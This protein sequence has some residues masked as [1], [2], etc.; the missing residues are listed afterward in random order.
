MPA[1]LRASSWAHTP[2]NCP[3]ALPMAAS[4]VFV[5]APWP[6]GRDGAVVLGGDDQNGVSCTCGGAEVSGGLGHGALDVDVLVVER[7]LA[8]ALVDAQRNALRSVLDGGFGNLAV[9]GIRAQA[10]DEDQDVLFRH[11][12]FLWL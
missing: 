3:Y 2:P 1:D 9:D 10:T 7:Q 12:S 5:M 11:G 4:G 8:E 6:N